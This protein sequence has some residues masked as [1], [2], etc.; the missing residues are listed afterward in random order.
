MRTVWGNAVIRYP[1]GGRVKID[2]KGKR[3]YEIEEG[4][5]LD[6]YDSEV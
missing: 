5:L 3:T 1:G 2:L 6:F 4:K